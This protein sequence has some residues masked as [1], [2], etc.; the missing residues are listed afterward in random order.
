MSIR[1]YIVDDHPI[2]RA[3]LVQ[4]ISQDPGLELAGEE[5]DGIRALERMRALKPEVAVLDIEVPGCSGLEL[6]GELSRM[7]P[8]VAVV[9]LTMHKEES[10]F[11]QAMDRGV[12]GYILKENAAVDLINGIKAVHK[13]ETFL[14]PSISGYLLNRRRRR[15]TLFETVPGLNLLTPMEKRVLRLTGENKTCKEIGKELFI[16][17]RTVETHRNNIAQKLGLRG[18]HKLLQFAI[19]HRS[20]L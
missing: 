6:A 14:T 18:S 2:F 4:V 15:D 5:S 9:I 17:H 10:V 13:G 3:G 19:E 1:V 12:M 20:E 8:P 16:S 11:N 7:K